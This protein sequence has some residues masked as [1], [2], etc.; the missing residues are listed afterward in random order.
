MWIK[1]SEIDSSECYEII[2]LPHRD[3]MVLTGDE[4]LAWISKAKI[5]SEIWDDRIE[6]SLW[7]GDDD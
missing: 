4:V 1:I 3:R 2:I 7:S 5:T 6:C